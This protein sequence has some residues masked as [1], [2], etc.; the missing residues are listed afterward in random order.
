MKPPLQLPLPG[1]RIILGVTG[2]I[3]AYKTAELVRLFKKAG[4]EVQVQIGHY[5]TS[6]SKRFDFRDFRPLC[7]PLWR[8]PMAQGLFYPRGAAVP[9]QTTQ[10]APVRSAMH[11]AP[12]LP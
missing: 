2:G 4:A 12:A 9:K 6:G 11:P 5:I 1:K 3:A 8:I 10:S 7:Q